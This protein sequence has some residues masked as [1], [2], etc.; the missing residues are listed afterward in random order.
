M[1]KVIR[2]WKEVQHAIGF[3]EI[4]MAPLI[5]PTIFSN[6]VT[7]LRCAS[8]SVKAANAIFMRFHLK[9]YITRKHITL[10][11]CVRMFYMQNC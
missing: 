8:W 9:Y 2:N 10:I 1:Y 7:V 5:W 4:S 3:I 11:L 6:V